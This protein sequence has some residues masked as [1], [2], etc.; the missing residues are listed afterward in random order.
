MSENGIWDNLILCSWAAVTQ[1]WLQNKTPLI[2]FE[3][4]AVPYT[5]SLNNI[6]RNIRMKHFTASKREIK[7]GRI[8]A[9][10]HSTAGNKHIRGLYLKG[11]Q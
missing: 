2:F 1:I 6:P 8:K 9:V 10:L 5:Y 7:L 11:Q 3:G 4:K